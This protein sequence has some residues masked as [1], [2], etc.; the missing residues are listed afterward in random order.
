VIAARIDESKLEPIAR[1]R[2]GQGMHCFAYL[3]KFDKDT[4]RFAAVCVDFGLSAHG[5]S[6]EEA[7]KNLDHL[8]DAFFELA[9]EKGNIEAILNR[10]TN[11]A[12]AAMLR[13][14]QRAQAIT[15]RLFPLI[16]FCVAAVRLFAPPPVEEYRERVELPHGMAFA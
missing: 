6:V 11:A 9:L 8:L 10:P 12:A 4:P 16:R 13:R 2:L 3:E 14:V 5:S 1:E 15:I 7:R